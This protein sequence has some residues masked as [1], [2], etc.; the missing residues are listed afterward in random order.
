HPA[1]AIESGQLSKEQEK[2]LKKLY[3][4]LNPVKLKNA[5]DAKLERLYNTYHK[6]KKGTIT[7]NPYKKLAPS[8]VTFF[9]I[10]QK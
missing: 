2:S 4:G 9:M 10:Q 1:F 5:I 8:S 3:R 7:V 6:K